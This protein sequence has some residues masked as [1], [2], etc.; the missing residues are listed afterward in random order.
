[1]VRSVTAIIITFRIEIPATTREIPP[2]ACVKKDIE[3]KDVWM[4]VR[5]CFELKTITS[6][7]FRFSRSVRRRVISSISL[8]S[9]ILTMT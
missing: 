3:E 7:S 4:A 5:N 8:I 1:L 6:F 9:F 2:T